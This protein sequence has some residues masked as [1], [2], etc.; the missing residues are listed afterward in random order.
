MFLASEESSGTRAPKHMNSAKSSRAATKQTRFVG[1]H[2]EIRASSYILQQQACKLCLNP[3]RLSFSR[4]KHN[5]LVNLP[6]LLRCIRHVGRWRVSSSRV[7]PSLQSPADQS[8][9][10]RP[11]LL[12]LSCLS[13]EQH[14]CP[15]FCMFLLCYVPRC[16]PCPLNWLPLH[17][18]LEHF[19]YYYLHYHYMDLHQLALG[20]L[21]SYRCPC[22]WSSA[23]WCPKLKFFSFFV[24]SEMEPF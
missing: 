9:L 18:H 7:A 10:Q 24:L 15:R 5:Q 3:H 19:H 8:L 22:H 1:N 13:A 17:Y 20:V 6:I 23:I 12:V 16:Y 21:V 14:V 4:S 11:P 2:W